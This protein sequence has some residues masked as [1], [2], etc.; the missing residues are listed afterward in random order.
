MAVITISRQSG[1]G[2]DEIA[3][4]L[5]MKLSYQT[6]DKR[7]IAKA[8]HEIGLTGQDIIDFS[9]DD[10]KI[11]GFFDR[12]FNRPRP[13]AQIRVWK[14]SV[15]G[16]RTFETEL[17][18]EDQAAGLVQSAIRAAYRAGDVIIVGRGGQVIL[19]DK[20]GVLHVRIEAPLEDRIERMSDEAGITP[21][22]AQ[23]A[24]LEH[25]RSAAAYLQRFHRADWADPLLYHLVINTGLISI[26]DATQL[27][28]T[29][30][31]LITLKEV[32][33]T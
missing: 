19:K 4:R 25:D 5:S 30:L 24:I 18:D 22:E 6:F 3:A 12:L 29:A 27:V 1:S 31:S 23:D 7:Q 15:A 2:G 9:E 8:A 32:V 21:E 33:R 26:E 11:R 14:E 13:I 10:Y 28:I 16:T 20:P 17:L